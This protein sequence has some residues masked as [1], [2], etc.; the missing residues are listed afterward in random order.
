LAALTGVCR[1][2]GELGVEVRTPDVVAEI[3]TAMRTLRLLP[4][5]VVDALDRW[6]GVTRAP[7][8]VVAAELG[9]LLAAAFLGARA[10][11]GPG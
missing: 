3:R 2:V 1:R 5:D 11:S 4:P 6:D 8:E 7:S 10:A 9:A